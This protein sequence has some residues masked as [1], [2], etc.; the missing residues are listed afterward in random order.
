MWPV[1]KMRPVGKIWPPGEMRPVGQNEVRGTKCGR[2]DSHT[3]EYIPL[4]KPM[5]QETATLSANEN[6]LSPLSQ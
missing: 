4:L 2:S 5:F 1:G 6:V 3:E